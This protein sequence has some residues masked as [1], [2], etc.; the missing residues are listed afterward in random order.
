MSFVKS[1]PYLTVFILLAV[2]GYYAP[3]RLPN[4]DTGY[5]D[6]IVETIK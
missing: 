2:I 3:D 4:E 1:H 5:N 6:T